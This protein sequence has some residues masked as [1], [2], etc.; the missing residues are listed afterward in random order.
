[1]F[2][3]RSLPASINR[4]EG[5]LLISPQTGDSRRRKE[6]RDGGGER[7]Q[8]FH[9]GRVRCLAAA[10]LARASELTDHSAGVPRL[11]SCPPCLCRPLAAHHHHSRGAALRPDHISHFTPSRM[12]FLLQETLLSTGVEGV[13]AGGGGA[14]AS[15]RYLK[16]FHATRP[17]LLTRRDETLPPFLPPF[18]HPSK[19]YTLQHISK[20]KL[21]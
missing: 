4:D 2:R 18:L 20:P 15:P 10:P 16:D 12:S 5:T 19:C 11:P 7:C 14:A 6:R 3:P 9:G 8:G 13:W 1:M 21:S 17:V